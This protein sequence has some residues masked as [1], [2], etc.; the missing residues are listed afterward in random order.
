[1]I[2][3]AAT[4]LCILACR[5]PVDRGKADSLAATRLEEYIRAERLNPEQFGRPEVREQGGEWLYIYEYHASPKQSVA[6]TVFAD[7]QVELS[8]MLENSR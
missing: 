4:G 2:I 5:P 1:M 6:V 8:R 3:M 7:G